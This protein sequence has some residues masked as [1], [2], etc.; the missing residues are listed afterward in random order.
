LREG[1]ESPFYWE[2]WQET[3]DKAVYV[4][5]EGV[6]WTLYQDGDLFAVA[7]DMLTDAEQEEFFEL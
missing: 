2:V 7:V 1:P 5:H 3:L 6:E 4:D